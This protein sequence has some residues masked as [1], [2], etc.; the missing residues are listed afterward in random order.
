MV[1][2]AALGAYTCCIS[3]LSNRVVRMNSLIILLRKILVACMVVAL[4]GSLGIL[5]LGYTEYLGGWLWGQWIVMLY[6]ALLGFH[7]YKLQFVDPED[8]VRKSRMQAA[9]RLLLVIALVL[10]S[11]KFAFI[12]P[13]MVVCSFLITKPVLYI[14]YWKYD[15]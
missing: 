13:F 7:S 8:I 15:H 14:V 9:Q 10:I 1:L 6:L 12:N 4:L 11:T 3:K 5:S 2:L